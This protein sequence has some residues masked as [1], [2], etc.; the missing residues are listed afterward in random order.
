MAVSTT[1]QKLVV[2]GGGLMISAAVLL[3][4]CQS[5]QH[6]V[7]YWKPRGPD[8][9]ESPKEPRNRKAEDD[10]PVVPASMAVIWTDGV[11]SHPQQAAT[12]GFGARIYFYDAVGKPV[13]VDGELVVY[14]FDD[15]NEF[16]LRTAAD[17]KYVFPREGLQGH[18][19]PSELGHSY[20]VWIPWDKVG[21]LRKTITLLP[22]FQASDGQLVKAAQ[23]INVLPGVS[24]A[25]ESVVR[26]GNP[27]RTYGPPAAPKATYDAAQANHVEST[28][29]PDAGTGQP[30][31][32]RT[33]TINVP[34]D[35]GQRMTESPNRQVQTELARAIDSAMSHDLNPTGH[36]ID[37]L[38]TGIITT[39]GSSSG[40]SVVRTS[41]VPINA[42]PKSSVPV[43]SGAGLPLSAQPPGLPVAPIE[44]TPTRRPV[45][46]VP[47]S[48]R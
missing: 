44:S 43:A 28:G 21:G 19:S 9:A 45:F 1:S 40:P 6:G 8:V 2:R 11:L 35:L 15:S 24:P 26:I 36:A 42:Q 37:D 41:G 4:G 16:E 18:Y 34:H 12:R 46:G 38:T 23:S 47:G 7:P 39:T 25:G 22:V 32:L 17:R 3:A 29:S 31:S 33:T 48:V 14:A 27:A 13:R 5:I 20:S 10:V 30:G